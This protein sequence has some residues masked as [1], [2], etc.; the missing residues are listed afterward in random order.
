MG[1]PAVRGVVGLV[2]ISA[3]QKA[4]AASRTPIRACARI[5]L[6]ADNPTDA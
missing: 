1:H 6:C 4:N 5:P 3:G 2:T